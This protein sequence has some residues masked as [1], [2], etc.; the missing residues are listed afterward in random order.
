VREVEA[1]GTAYLV[2]AALEL[3]G[4]DDSRGYLQH[5]SHGQAIDETTARRIFKAADLILRAGREQTDS[6]AAS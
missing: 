4:A 2:A 1:E 6:E 5:W 3:P